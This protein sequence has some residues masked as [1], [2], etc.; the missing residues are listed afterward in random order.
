[1]AHTRL[2]VAVILV[3]LVR[4]TLQTEWATYKCYDNFTLRTESI[5]S[6]HVV[7]SSA[8]CAVWCRQS[9]GCSV[10]SYNPATHVCALGGAIK[11]G[12]LTE[13]TQWKTC[14]NTEGMYL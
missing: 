8:E 12:M 10:Y 4:K 6:T 1:M 7:T 11:D 3:I 13:D 9:A 14:F 5:S 2:I